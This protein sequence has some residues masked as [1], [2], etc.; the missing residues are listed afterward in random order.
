MSGRLVGKVA[1]VT[2]GARGIGA[3]I[4]KRLA[5]D[6]AEIVITY[7]ASP[8]KA[9]ALVA[10]IK[11]SGGKAIAVAADAANSAATRAAVQLAVDSFGGLDILVNNAG[12][13]SVA[14]IDQF[15]TADFERM[16]D[17]NIKGMVVATQEAVRH[18]RDGG[19]IILIGSCNS[20][21]V[22]FQGGSIYALTKAAVV[23]FAKGLARDL[24]PRGITVN[25]VQPGPT[26]TDMN[27][28]KGEGAKS[29]VQ[30]VAL[31]RYAS[32]EEIADFVAYLAGP[33]ASFITGAS[34]LIDGGYAA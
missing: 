28:A 13:V 4:A 16:I 6:G 30:N 7:S 3:G 31:Q 12:I 29:T 20:E 1:L 14:P 2:G 26:D 5:S 18:M 10:S 21:R 15:K 8:D 11:Q 25:N 19:R 27:P 9:N 32:V 34:L 22:P 17:I 24:G 33:E 23:G